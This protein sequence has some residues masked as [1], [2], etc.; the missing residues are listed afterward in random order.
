[1]SVV[2]I[3]LHNSDL[4]CPCGTLKR[5]AGDKFLRFLFT[6]CSKATQVCVII[7]LNILSVIL[8]RPYRIAEYIE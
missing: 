6:G 3:S 2:I 8:E 4:L 7:P 1:M 5:V